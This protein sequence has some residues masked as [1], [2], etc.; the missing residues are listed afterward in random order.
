[1]NK[2]RAF[3]LVELLVVIAIITTIAGIALP[4]YSRMFRGV[5]L[6][7]A[8]RLIT[9]TLSAARQMAITQQV[10]S[11][12]V[13]DDAGNVVFETKGERSRYVEFDVANNRLRTYFWTR[14][15][16]QRYKQITVGEWEVLPQT[17]E[18][19]ESDTYK[20]YGPND[21]SDYYKHPPEYIRFKPN[22][23]AY[24]SESP[25]SPTVF[26]FAIVDT[27]SGEGAKS[28][29]RVVTVQGV[30]GMARAEAK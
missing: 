30:T 12:S 22:G 2:Y 5:H 3:T 9:Q 15:D 27:N 8:S 6:T 25:D 29:T 14:K 13:E 10:Y 16:G 18:F 26:D 7:N 4:L 23:T 20:W 19:Y 24:S 11:C 28:K 17:I 21:K 1:M